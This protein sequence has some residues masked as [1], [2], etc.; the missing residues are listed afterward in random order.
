MNNRDDPSSCS[1]T[2]KGLEKDI[3]LF[4]MVGYA[5]DGVKLCDQITSS[6]S[7]KKDCGPTPTNE[8]TI[9]ETFGTIKV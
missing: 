5:K 4:D 9:I 7:Y 1:K 3:C 6:E 2:F 8:T